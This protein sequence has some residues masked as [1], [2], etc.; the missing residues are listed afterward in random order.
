[1]FELYPYD[2]HKSF[3]GKAKVFEGGNGEKTLYS[4]GTAILRLNADGSIKR[5]WYGWSATTG[6]H[7][8][9]FCAHYG[10]NGGNKKWFMSL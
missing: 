4:Y 6:R 7:I 10:I 1:M 8:A 3:Y 2:S 5:L 9:A